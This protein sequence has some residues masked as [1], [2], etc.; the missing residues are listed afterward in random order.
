MGRAYPRSEADP[1]R[2]LRGFALFGVARPRGHCLHR[3]PPRRIP[4][5][6]TLIPAMPDS[7]PPSDPGTH[8]EGPPR[9]IRPDSPPSTIREGG[10]LDEWIGPYRI[11]R[12]LGRGGQGVVAVSR[13][14]WTLAWPKT[15]RAKTATSRG[16]A[17]CSARLPTWPPSRSRAAPPRATGALTCGRSESRSM[18]PFLVVVRSKPPRAHCS[19]NKSR[20]SNQSSP[21]ATTRPFL[22]T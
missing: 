19:F 14:S 5:P 9:E 22:A 12:E 6:V 8:P 11:E 4:S 2:C 13:A 10:G 3:I 18:R 15:S 16:L 21:D 1:V 20:A 7:K 17:I